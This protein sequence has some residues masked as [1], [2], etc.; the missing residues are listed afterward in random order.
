[1]P[2]IQI[3]ATKPKDGNHWINTGPHIMVVSAD[4]SFYDLYPED[5]DPDVNQPYVMWANMPYVHLMAPVK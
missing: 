5:T 2:A 3:H 1:M 4:S